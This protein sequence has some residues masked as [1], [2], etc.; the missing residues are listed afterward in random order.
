M[1][2][3]FL[4]STHSQFQL[5]M[6]PTCNMWIQSST[7]RPPV[8]NHHKCKFQLAFWSLV[9]QLAFHTLFLFPYSSELSRSYP[10]YAVG[11]YAGG[12]QF[13]TTAS[14]NF[15][16]S[17]PTSNGDGN[18]S[19]IVPENSILGVSQSRGSP[20]AISGVSLSSSTSIPICPAP[21]SILSLCSEF[22]VLKHFNHPKW[23]ICTI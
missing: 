14:G 11:D 21:Y 8:R 22:C 6:D 2:L 18:G 20:Q 23:K 5:R 3:Y 9:K 4:S 13:Y 16:T 19:Y 17:S 1:N 12:Q 15:T 10:V 7:Q